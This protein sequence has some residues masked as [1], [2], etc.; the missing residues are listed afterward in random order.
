MWLVAITLLVL[1]SAVTSGAL[2]FAYPDEITLKD[3][4]ASGIPDIVFDKPPT[5]DADNPAP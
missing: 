1:A 2:W 5:E 3:I 4:P